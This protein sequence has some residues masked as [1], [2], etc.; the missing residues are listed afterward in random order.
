[1]HVVQLEINGFRGIRHLRVRFEQQT[2]I[3]GPNGCGK[4]TIADALALVTCPHFLYQV[5]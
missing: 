1:M 3:I 2:V 4:T 5:L